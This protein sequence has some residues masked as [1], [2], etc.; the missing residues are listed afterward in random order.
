MKTVLIMAGGTGGHIFPALAVAKEL[1]KQQCNIYWLGSHT[2]MEKNIVPQHNIPIHYL[3]ITGLR[4]N[5]KLG[6]LLAPWRVTKAVLQ[7]IK[8]IKK[9]NP[10]VVVGLGGFASG[11]G[12]I[13]AKLLKKPLIIH[14][15][16]SIAGLTNRVLARFAK[17]VLQAFPNAFAAKYKPILVGN[18]VRQALQNLPPPRVRSWMQAGQLNILILGGSQGALSLNQTVPNALRELIANKQINVWHQC[19][20]KHLAL[21]TAAYQHSEVKLTPFIEDMAEAYTWADLVICRA[22][23]LTVAELMAVGVPSILIPYPY[24]VD[25]HQTKNALY[26]VNNHAAHLIP[27]QQLTA[28][29]IHSIVV[30]L[31]NNSSDLLEMAEK[32]YSL[33]KINATQDVANYCMEVCCGKSQ[34]TNASDAPD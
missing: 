7:A 19:G 12:G 9:I 16:N 23:A 13:A 15:Q 22:G 17:K 3:A 14:E 32:A 8:I 30:F 28:E 5:G 6:L 2:G 33:R 18:P 34:T 1:Q 24:A 27:P 10:D 29:A 26:L 21:T 20:E 25:D 11:P 31:L 4:G